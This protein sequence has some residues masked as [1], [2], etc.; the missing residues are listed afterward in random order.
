MSTFLA[1]GYIIMK[2][3]KIKAYAI[4][5]VIVFASTTVTLPAYAQDANQNLYEDF[6]GEA[7]AVDLVVIRPLGIVSTTIG[8]VLFA[9]SLPFTV[10][11]E[12]RIKRA[13]KY[14]V[15][16]PGRYAFVRPLGEFQDSY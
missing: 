1:W 9:A 4:I 13:A 5:L 7:M 10:W 8:C 6:P 3:F 12:E 16:E 11:T 14:F 2:W 15:L